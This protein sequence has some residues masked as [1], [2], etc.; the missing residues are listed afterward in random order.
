[1]VISPDSEIAA[2]HSKTAITLWD[3][4][5]G[6]ETLRYNL[7]P[8]NKDKQIEILT[9]DYV[10][11]EFSSSGQLVASWNDR[12]IISVW[13]VEDG[14]G[15]I[16][17]AS[18]HT[19]NR[20]NQQ[21]HMQEEP[22][23][24]IAFSS[25]DQFLAAGYKYGLIR[26]WDLTTKDKMLLQPPRD[27]YGEVWSVAFS[28]N[29]KILAAVYEGGLVKC[30]NH[31]DGKEHHTFRAHWNSCYVKFLNDKILESRADQTVQTWD[32]CPGHDEPF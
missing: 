27:S 30:W 6:E 22:I 23:T 29:G 3:I 19:I 7:S 17:Y 12:G 10:Q 28:P 25:N 8:S 26:V 11:V 9:E 31:E 1:V 20:R 24:S 16:G 18:D 14:Q 13:Q 4:A 32:I 15:L 2:A 5:T 21:L